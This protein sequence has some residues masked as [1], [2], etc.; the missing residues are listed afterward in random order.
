MGIRGVLVKVERDDKHRQ[1][2]WFISNNKKQRC[3]MNHADG[4][5]GCAMAARAVGSCDNENDVA[6]GLK[7]KPL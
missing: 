7:S 4:R 5:R 2:R 3:S 6:L 1:E